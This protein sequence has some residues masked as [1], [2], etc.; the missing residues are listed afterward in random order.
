MT[1][2]WKVERDRAEAELW[3]I[4]DEC[5][6]R[7]LKTLRRLPAAIDAWRRFAAASFRAGPR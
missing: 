5:K 4:H 1:F 6:G 7:P 3:F 2:D